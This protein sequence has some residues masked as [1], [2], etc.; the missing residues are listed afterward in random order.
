[1]KK[2][3]LTVTILSWFFIALG[4]ALFFYHF[5][6]IDPHRLFRSEDV[7]IPLSELVW[8]ASGAFMLLGRDWARWLLLAWIAFH[9]VLSFSHSLHEV[10][11]HGLL[12]VLIGYL[13]FRPEARAYFRRTKIKS[14]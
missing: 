11:V 13:L 12:F 3:P 4:A 8:V 7:W 1:M 9:V 10:V 5:P 14:G 2:R 6:V